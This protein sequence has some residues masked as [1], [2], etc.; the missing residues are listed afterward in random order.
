MHRYR[1]FRKKY[2]ALHILSIAVAIVM[3]WKGIWSLLDAYILPGH[4][5][6][7]NALLILIAFFVLYLDDFHLKELE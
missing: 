7:S 5:F 2:R 6:I 3:F 1:R 4:I